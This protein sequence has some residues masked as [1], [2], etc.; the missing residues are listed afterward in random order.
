MID[1][2][3]FHHTGMIVADIDQAQADLSRAL[4]VTWAPV[5]HFDPLAF[6][7]PEAGAHEVHVKATYSLGGPH[8]LELV[9]GD[10]P[11]YDPDRAPDARHLGIW[12]DDIAAEAQH[13]LAHGWRVVASG[14]SPDD[15]FGLIAYM[16]PP[17][18]GLL[19]EL[20]STALKPTLDEWLGE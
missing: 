3:R 4:G 10:G 6:W 1:L 12:V 11:F 20:I 19:I 15:G 18:P 2:Q 17:I 7:T 5:R 9:Q 13:L 16:A 8:H 14:A